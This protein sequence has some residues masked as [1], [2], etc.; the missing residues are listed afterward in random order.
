MDVGFPLE[1]SKEY[2]Q[3]LR[4][5][6][7]TKADDFAE[8][9]RNICKFCCPTVIIQQK[10]GSGLSALVRHVKSLHDNHREVVS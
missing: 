7:F 6:F 1:G 9:G 4:D 3:I 5:T 2:N 10:S 8:T